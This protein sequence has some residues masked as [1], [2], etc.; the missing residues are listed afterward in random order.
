MRYVH[1]LE[2]HVMVKRFVRLA[3]L[4]LSLGLNQSKGGKK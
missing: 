1:Q 4:I 2:I 3:G